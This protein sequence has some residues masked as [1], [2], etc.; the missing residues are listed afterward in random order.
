MG[1]SG[2][3]GV[4]RF[5]QHSSDDRSHIFGTRQNHTQIPG[6]V[7]RTTPRKRVRINAVRVGRLSVHVDGCAGAR[8][9]LASRRMEH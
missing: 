8:P 6:H 3:V 9:A 2:P 1:V 7:S 5:Y 4:I